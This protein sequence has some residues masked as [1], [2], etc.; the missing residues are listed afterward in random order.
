MTDD[1]KVRKMFYIR[2]Q[3]CPHLA[4]HVNGRVEE[5]CSNQAYSNYQALLKMYNERY[6]D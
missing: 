3:E 6:G 4:D 5:F 2:V 1:E